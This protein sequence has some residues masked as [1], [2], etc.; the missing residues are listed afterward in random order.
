MTWDHLVS[1]MANT[2][3]HLPPHLSIS[4]TKTKLDICP[5]FSGLF[6]KL[7]WLRKCSGP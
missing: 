5:H 7:N 6:K 1:E 3:P 4:S 2:C